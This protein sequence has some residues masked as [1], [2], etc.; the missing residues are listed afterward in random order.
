MDAARAGVADGAMGP[1]RAADSGEPRPGAVPMVAETVVEQVVQALA[2]GE[3]VTAVARAYQLDRKTVRTWRDRG[4]YGPRA[5]RAPVSQLDPYRAWLTRR[6]PEVGHNAAVV[7][8][9]L[10]EQGFA[11]SYVIVRLAAVRDCPL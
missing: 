4:R 5:P 10:R 11:G 3:S 1:H 9:E 6:A 8:R 7:Y 2:R